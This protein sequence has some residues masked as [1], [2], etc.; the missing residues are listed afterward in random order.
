MCLSQEVPTPARPA[1]MPSIWAPD[2]RTSSEA[3]LLRRFEAR[4][5]GVG[6]RTIYAQELTNRS[7][8]D[9]DTAARRVMQLERLAGERFRRLPEIQVELRE[10]S[11]ITGTITRTLEI[12]LTLA[13]NGRRYPTAL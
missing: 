9:L 4:R 2:H 13:H 5:R 11:Q 12:T 7:V 3:K 1:E 8:A 6:Q 10:E